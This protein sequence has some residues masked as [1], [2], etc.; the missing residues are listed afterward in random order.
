MPFISPLSPTLSPTLSPAVAGPEGGATSP[1]RAA[2]GR[3]NAYD[4]AARFLELLNQGKTEQ[5]LAHYMQ[6]TG[7]QPDQLPARADHYQ[8]DLIAQIGAQQTMRNYAMHT[9]PSLFKNIRIKD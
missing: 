1:A 9:M 3:S 8:S 2:S 7:A 5:A 4:D 6:V